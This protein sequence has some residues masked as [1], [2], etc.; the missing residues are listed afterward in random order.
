MLQSLK[1][2]NFRCFEEFELQNLGRIN[3]LVGENN[4]GKTSVLEAIQIFSSHG[5]L[6]TIFNLMT[7]RG[8]YWKKINENTRTIK[9]QREY[10]I[11]HLFHQHEIFS[12]IEF[13]LIGKSNVNQEKLRVF[14][15]SNSRYPSP[16]FTDFDS[17]NLDL[18]E[19]GTLDFMVDWNS[20]G[21]SGD[22]IKIP[23][24]S[25]D[26]LDTEYIRRVNTIIPTDKITKTH[27]ITPFSLQAKE[28]TNLFDNVVLTPHEQLIIEV[29]Q[30]IE[31]EIERIASIA[32]K[33]TLGGISTGSIEKGGFLV[34]FAN[35]KN[36]I[37][38][39]SLGD[40]IWRILAIILVMVNLENG[41]LLIDE[42]DTGLHFTTLFDMWKV[43]LATARKLNIQVFATTHNSDC[44]TSLARLIQSEEIEPNEITIQRIESNKKQSVTFNEQQIVIAA[45]REIEV[46]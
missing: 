12:G 17:E 27:F 3:L 7:Y 1:I 19:D 4:S 30:I 24:S 6:K 14:V 37:P 18:E 31:P 34:K 25:N 28:L 29:L 43:I 9:V 40:G 11:K 5:D 22:L 38:I 42:I 35:Q 20:Q 8:E 13:S 23:L 16:D 15:Q 10:D 39:G 46:R 26:S 21:N 36:P 33:L 32:P 44:W 41:I 45:E 2:Q